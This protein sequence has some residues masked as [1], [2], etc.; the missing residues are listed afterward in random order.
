MG[1]KLKK[2]SGKDLVKILAF[3]GFELIKQKGSHMK[4][5][6]VV[7]GNNETLIVQNDKV[8]PIGTLKSI[9]NS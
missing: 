9:F 7:L 2:L 3:F 6:R 5:R 8:I 1:S 4:L